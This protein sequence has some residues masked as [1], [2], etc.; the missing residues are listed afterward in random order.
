LGHEEL[1]GKVFLVIVRTMSATRSRS[2][3][4]SP[5][6][7]P[8]VPRAKIQVTN[9][10]GLKKK[11]NRGGKNKKKKGTGIPQADPD[12][13]RYTGPLSSAAINQGTDVTVAVL[14]D[15]SFIQAD[16]TGHVTTVWDNDPAV[17]LNW[18]DWAANFAEYRTLAMYIEFEPDNRYNRPTTDNLKSMG[19]IVNRDGNTLPLAG[20]S[21]AVEHPSF[22][23]ISPA[24]PWSFDNGMKGSK[25]HPPTWR[26]DGVEEAGF[27]STTAHGP[28]GAIKLYGD[29]FTNSLTF[30]RYVQTWIVQFRYRY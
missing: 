19:C 15:T 23:F 6:P 30:G 25:A 12:S 29:G 3:G 27:L 26:M 22:R 14:K 28:L 9:P 18:S 11:V 24:D 7:P 8:R 16:A 4:R 10:S 20:W 1:L 21:S 5:A 2:V 17:A 13:I